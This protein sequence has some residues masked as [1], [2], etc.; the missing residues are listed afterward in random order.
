MCDKIKLWKCED[1]KSTDRKPETEKL[2][3]YMS[4]GGSL[5]NYLSDLRCENSLEKA[6]TKLLKQQAE[7]LRIKNEKNNT[8]KSESILDNT[9]YHPPNCAVCNWCGVSIWKNGIGMIIEEPECCTAQ[10]GKKIEKCYDNDNCRALFE[11][12]TNKQ[13]D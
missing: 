2:S 13:Q 4:D 6:K 8:S 9:D 7:A 5:E 1:G 10:G 11:T 12:N 3:V